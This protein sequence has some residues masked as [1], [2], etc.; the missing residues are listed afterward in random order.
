M[1]R[2]SKLTEAQWHDIEKRMLAGEKAAVLA[3]EYGID[4]PVCGM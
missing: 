3:K 4:L 2:T 1:A